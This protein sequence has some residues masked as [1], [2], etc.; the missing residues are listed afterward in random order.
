MSQALSFTAGV[1]KKRRKA[2]KIA[3]GI[4]PLE[5][6]NLGGLGVRSAGKRL[7]QEDFK[8]QLLCG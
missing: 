8:V 5:K 4:K 7:A 2:T 3:A 6:D 1:G